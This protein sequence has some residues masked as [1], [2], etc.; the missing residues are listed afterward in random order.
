LR[1]HG[2]CVAEILDDVKVDADLGDAFG[3]GLYERELRYLIER[4]W[5]RTPEDVLWRR[6]KC[7]IHMTAAQRERVAAFMGATEM[8]G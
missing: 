8:S 7:G 3:G 2:T 5:A 1:R 4:E 6:T